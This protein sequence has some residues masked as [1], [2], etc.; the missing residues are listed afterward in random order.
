MQGYMALLNEGT[1]VWRP[2]ELSETGGVLI[3]V[4]KEPDDEEWQFKP[5]S[6]VRLDRQQHSDGEVDV[7]VASGRLSGRSNHIMRK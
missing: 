5:G 3:V 6:I 4:G 1:D 7:I 2:V